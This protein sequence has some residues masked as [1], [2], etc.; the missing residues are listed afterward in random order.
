MENEVV[1]VDVVYFGYDWSDERE[2]NKKL[3]QD[4]IVKLKTKFPNAQFKDAYDNIKGFRQEVYLE[5]LNKDD[6]FSWLIG[7]G[8]HEMS[9]TIQM[10]IMGAGIDEQLKERAEKY[11][12]LA[13]AQYPEAFKTTTK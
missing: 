1:Y 2:G 6:Y 5:E 8:W 9:L 13:K 7:N 11:I 12:N 10:T 3:E 4:F